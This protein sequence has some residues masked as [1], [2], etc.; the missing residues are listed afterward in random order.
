MAPSYRYS[1][2]IHY[3]VNRLALSAQNDP[4]KMENPGHGFMKA[5]AWDAQPDA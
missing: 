4:P 3:T 2:F 1:A 5:M